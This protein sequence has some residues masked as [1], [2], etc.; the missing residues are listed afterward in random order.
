MLL[1][2]VKALVCVESGYRIATHWYNT[3]VIYSEI[4]S[5][6]NGGKM[7]T[8]LYDWLSNDNKGLLLHT[9]KRFAEE[10]NRSKLLIEYIDLQNSARQRVEEIGSEGMKCIVSFG[11]SMD[12]ALY[13]LDRLKR[14][15]AID[16][17]FANL[18]GVAEF[19]DWN[20]IRSQ[21]PDIAAELENTLLSFI[22]GT[23]FNNKTEWICTQWIHNITLHNKSFVEKLLP[24]A[25]KTTSQNVINYTLLA[26]TN[27]NC[28]DEYYPA[29]TQL[30]E[31]VIGDNVPIGRMYLYS[32]FGFRMSV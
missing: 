24:L 7:P 12:L 29:I 32:S 27:S 15:N 4:A 8:D 22:S 1:D 19:L 21:A 25:N 16:I 20:Y 23:L 18:V 26:M 11:M 2:K 17:Q 31:K 30:Q 14:I 5:L 13:L 3:I 10:K 6:K 9:D 28:V